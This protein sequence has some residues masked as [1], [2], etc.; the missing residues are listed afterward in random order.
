MGLSFHYSGRFNP[1]KLLKELVEEVSD[2]CKTYNW[3]YHV[4]NN[5][6]PDRVFTEDYNDE[7][8]GISFTPPECETVFM[9]FLSNGRLSSRPNLMFFGNSNNA[10]Y[11]EYLYMLSV[12]TQF[13]GI[14]VHALLIEIFRHISTKYFLDFKLTDEG[15]YWETGDLKELEKQFKRYNMLMNNFCLGLET[16]PK[17]ETENLEAYLIRLFKYISKE[18][19]K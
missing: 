15:N 8:Y 18:D 14:E 6:F 11:K 1:E 13:A 4:I 9:S 7:D 3:K 10:D 19:R 5:D 2:I 12:K 17:F 16:I